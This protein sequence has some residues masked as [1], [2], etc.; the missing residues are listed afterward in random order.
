MLGVR[1]VAVFGLLALSATGAGETG[2]STQFCTNSV[3]GPTPVALDLSCAATN[4][5]SVN[6]SGPCNTADASPGLNT[7]IYGSHVLVYSELPGVCHVV[8]TFGDGFT[9]STDVD[10]KWTGSS[11]C[12]A[13]PYIAPTQSRFAVNN[14]SSTCADGGDAAG[15]SG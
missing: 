10:F 4:V 14:P 6:L 12:A 13:N 9:Y 1:H 15:A 8:L 5:T 2:C 11:S 7:Y 3:Q